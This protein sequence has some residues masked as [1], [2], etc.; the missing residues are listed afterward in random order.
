MRNILF[1]EKVGRQL[2]PDAGA[3]C[4]ETRITASTLVE[5]RSKGN[6]SVSSVP[7][8][9]EGEPST[10]MTS[11]SRKNGLFVLCRIWS[12]EPRTPEF[13]GSADVIILTSS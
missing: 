5:T 10:S 12:P 8:S 4:D 2:P 11:S 7:T 6:W 13:C 1:D 3:G 9:E